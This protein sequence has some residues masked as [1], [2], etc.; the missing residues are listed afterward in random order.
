MNCLRVLLFLQNLFITERTGDVS[1]YYQFDE[2]LGE[3]TYGIVF[4]AVEI[5]SGELRAIK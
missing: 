2:K 1:N 3:G 4:K 5:E